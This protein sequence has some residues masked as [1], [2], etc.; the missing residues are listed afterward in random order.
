MHG[1]QSDEKNQESIDRFL[2]NDQ[3]R[4]FIATP[5]KAGEGLTL[6]V[7]N[8]A[9]FYDRSFSLQHYL[10]AQDRIHRISQD[11]ICYIYNLMIRGSIDE[12]IDKLVK[13]KHVTSQLAIG[14][15]SE[16]EFLNRGHFDLRKTLD[17][18][19]N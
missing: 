19:L 4:L 18:I 17:Q 3:T 16:E 11:R 14:D 2:E 15:I 7:A 1:Q 8:H 13:A 10:Q 9:F 6:T 12:Y 5:Q